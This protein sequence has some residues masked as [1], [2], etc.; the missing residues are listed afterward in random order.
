MKGPFQLDIPPH[1][2]ERIRKLPP[3][4]KQGLKEALRLLS[5]DPGA[6]EPLRRELEGYWKYRVRRYRVVYQRVRGVVRVVGVG[7]RRT[8]Y[9][10][11]GERL[12]SETN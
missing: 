8:I 5:R 12:R 2:A 9:E 4:V 10:E 7:H 6:G 3:E 11:L 1:V